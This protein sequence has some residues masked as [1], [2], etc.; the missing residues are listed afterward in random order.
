MNRKIFKIA[1]V[2]CVHGD[3]II[4]IKVIKELKKAKVKEGFV[5]DFFIGNQPAYEKR[6]RWIK[7]DLNRS[8]PGKKNGQNEEKI[9]YQLRKALSCYDLVIDIHATNSDI[10]RLAIVTKYDKEI[11]RML[12]F[13][14]IEKVALVKKNVFGGKELISHVQRGIALEFGPNKKM[15]NYPKAL[16]VTRQMLINIGALTGKKKLKQKSEVFRVY[17]IYKVGK[18]F[19]QNPALKDFR[20]IKTRQVIGQEG[21]TKIKA[22]KIFYPL[23][24]GKGRYKENSA[25]AL[26]AKKMR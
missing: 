17:G 19:Q 8:F 16:D 2:G 4:G 6:K 13:V 20:L 3:E 24:L 12:R 1:I 10:D 15:A 26:M 22:E 5:L 25:L 21:K 18:K 23:F 14:P 7:K 11:K 9:A